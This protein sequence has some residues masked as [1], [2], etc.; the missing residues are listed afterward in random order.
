M[1]L[2]ENFSYKHMVISGSKIQFW[3]SV[4]GSRRVLVFQFYGA[5]LK[6][7]LMPVICKAQL[8]RNGFHAKRTAGDAF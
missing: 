4:F 1:G 5:K 8:G 3:K 6:N 2:K 7:L